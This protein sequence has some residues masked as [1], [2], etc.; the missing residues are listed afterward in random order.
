M[1]ERKKERGEG[2]G[3]KKNIRA[4]EENACTAGYTDIGW[5]FINML[6]L[7]PPLRQTII[8]IMEFQSCWQKLDHFILQSTPTTILIR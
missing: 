4:S 5:H 3:R 2:E 1:L 8:V 6:I 7:F